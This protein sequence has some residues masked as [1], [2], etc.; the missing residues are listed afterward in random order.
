M[1]QIWSSEDC[2]GS[3]R[4]FGESKE[5]F[6]NQY[7]S[8]LK[9]VFVFL[10]QSLDKQSSLS[11]SSQ[12]QITT[13]GSHALLTYSKRPSHTNAQ[14]NQRDFSTGTSLFSMLT[15]HRMFPELQ[16]YLGELPWRGM[17]ERAGMHTRGENRPCAVLAL[18]VTAHIYLFLRPRAM[19]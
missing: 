19:S 10:R 13:V 12:G 8:I 3:Q 9:I 4:G 1:G 5:K 15:L 16:G 2:G 11:P 7:R 17:Y 6:E 18:L 14:E